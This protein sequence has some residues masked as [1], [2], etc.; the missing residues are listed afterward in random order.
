[1]PR[2]GPRPYDCIRRAWHSDRHQPMR[3]LLIQEI[4][5]SSSSFLSY[6]VSI[7][8]CIGVCV[9]VCACLYLCFL[10]LNCSWTFYFIGLFVRF[11]AN[12]PRRTLNGKR[13]SLWLSWE[14]KK[15]CI[16]KPILRFF[17]LHFNFS[18]CVLFEISNKDCYSIVLIAFYCPL[19]TVRLIVLLVIYNKH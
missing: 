4:F 2:P 9:C 3:G 19:W 5:R 8:V 1:M 6:S 15:S 7:C 10:Q 12:P 14:L 11:T 13:S 17:F 18:F 16:P